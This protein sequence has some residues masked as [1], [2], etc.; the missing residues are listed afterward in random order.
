MQ[1][2]DG[3]TILPPINWDAPDSIF[4]SDAC[5]KSCG[6]WSEG[7]A[8]KADFPKW[9]I[10]KSEV[11]INE[12]ELITFIVA[13]KIWKD[14]IENR[15][16]LAYCNNEVSVEVVNLGRANKHFTQAC[17]R[18]ICYLTAKANTVIKLVHISSEANRISDYLLRWGQKSEAFYELV[19]KDNVSFI[20][21]TDDMFKFSHDW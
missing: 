15:N 16:V 18:E 5:L 10:Q 12:L 4:S 14:R 1:D 13:L 21:V 2:F 11:H 8:F 20:A 17:L 7:E 3:I 9:L 6:G 19:G